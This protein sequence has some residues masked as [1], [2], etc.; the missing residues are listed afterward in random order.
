PRAPPPPRGGAPPPARAGPGAPRPPPPPPPVP[1][2]R[3]PPGRPAAPPPRTPRRHGGR[4]QRLELGLPAAWSTGAPGQDRGR[5][6]A[7][8]GNLRRG[9]F[10][11]VRPPA[12][13][14]GAARIRDRRPLPGRVG[15][16]PGLA[17]QRAWLPAAVR[18]GRQ[19]RPV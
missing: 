11:R 4:T 5:Q 16:G 17:P 2:R 13:T 9:G 1:P 10:R 3:W 18:R 7:G 6:A 12:G 15:G 8:S 19:R 14:A